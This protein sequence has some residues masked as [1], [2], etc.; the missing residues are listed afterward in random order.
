MRGPTRA[1][2]PDAHRR[3]R[4][5]LRYGIPLTGQTASS[6]LRLSF[7]RTASAPRAEFQ[8]NSGTRSYDGVRAER[9]PVS[10]QRLGRVPVQFR[11]APAKRLPAPL[12]QCTQERDARTARS[13]S[14]S[15]AG[16]RGWSSQ[17][18]NGDNTRLDGARAHLTRSAAV[19][20]PAGAKVGGGIPAVVRDSVEE[21]VA[22][23]RQLR[24]TALRPVLS[25]AARD[26][27]RSANRR[28]H[29]PFTSPG[30]VALFE[31]APAVRAGS[32]VRSR[33][34]GENVGGMYQIESGLRTSRGTTTGLRRCSIVTPLKSGQPLRYLHRVV[35][36]RDRDQE[37]EHGAQ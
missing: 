15:N 37:L 18:T 34:I 11:G 35:T 17:R 32:P 6:A 28:F 33:G 26:V 21:Q 2:S 13:I 1:L 23:A 16:P 29:R 4:L 10:H 25:R 30:A 19:G 12:W 14:F 5:G 7:L 31:Y 36:K 24:I 9:C 8:H 3:A 22:I 20:R 27:V